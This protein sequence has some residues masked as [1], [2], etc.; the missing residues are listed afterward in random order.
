[1]SSYVEVLFSTVQTVCCQLHMVRV[2]GSCLRTEQ[3]TDGLIMVAIRQLPRHTSQAGL[4]LQASV[5]CL[6][7]IKFKSSGTRTALNV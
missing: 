6:W 3:A 7:R 1:M 2:F 4:C 5:S